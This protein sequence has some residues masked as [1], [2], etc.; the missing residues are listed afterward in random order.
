MRRNSV[1]GDGGARYLQLDF[2]ADYNLSK[3]TDLYALTVVQRASGRDSLNQPAV[4]SI[5]GFSP[6][7]SSRQVGVRIALR[8]K[9]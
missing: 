5:S 3:R 4:A 6:S 9:F 7:A 1:K 8:H 2:G